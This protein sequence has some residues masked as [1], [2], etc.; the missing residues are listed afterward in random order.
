MRGTKRFP[1]PVPHSWKPKLG[2]CLGSPWGTV[3][4]LVT[5]GSPR[6]AVGK[7]PSVSRAGALSEAVSEAGSQPRDLGQDSREGAVDIQR[8]PPALL[9]SQISAAPVLGS[10][11]VGAAPSH[12]LPLD[13][14]HIRGCHRRVVLLFAPEA[15]GDPHISIRV[16]AAGG[17]LLPQVPPTGCGAQIGD[18]NYGAGGHCP[19][20]WAPRC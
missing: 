1:V 18:S 9:G 19:F 8:S 14:A 7:A 16:P 4:G 20:T 12:V 3:G 13:L 5:G 11:A 15:M 6:A 10:R 2:R 17:R